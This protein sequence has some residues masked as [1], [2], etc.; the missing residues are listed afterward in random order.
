[1]TAY[2]LDVIQTVPNPVW[3]I[4]C[5]LA[6]KSFKEVAT[7]EAS[8]LLFNCIGICL[9]FKQTN[10]YAICLRCPSSV[11]NVLSCFQNCWNN[12]TISTCSSVCLSDATV[13]TA[14]S[15]EFMS[16]LPYLLWTKSAGLVQTVNWFSWLFLN[17]VSEHSA[18]A[19]LLTEMRVGNFW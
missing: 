13:P 1:M 14:Q 2:F 3:N 10:V 11:Q 8:V 9:V 18:W 15:F 16:V 19:V 5:F 6:A 17:Q 4:S 12:Y 7:V